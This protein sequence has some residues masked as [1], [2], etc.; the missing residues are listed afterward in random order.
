MTSFTVSKL[1]KASGVEL[2]TIRY[3]ER[4][5]LVLPSTRQDSGYRVY[6]AE[7]V[8]RVQFI[9]RAQSLGFTLDEIADLLQLRVAPGMDCAAVRARASAKLAEVNLRQADLKRIGDALEKMVAACPARGPVSKCT[10]LDTLELSS[11]ENDRPTPIRAN[12]QQKHGIKAMTSLLLRIDGMHCAGC[13]QIIEALLA[14]EPGVKSTSV[15]HKSGQGR[16]LY[17]PALTDADRI[18]EVIGQAGY[19]ARTGSGTATR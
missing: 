11:G 14:R 2:S 6:N 8:R 10:I 5:G 1:A 13:A 17:D 19:R 18:V 4:R 15:S 7:S 12:T 16:V 9:R 3:Y